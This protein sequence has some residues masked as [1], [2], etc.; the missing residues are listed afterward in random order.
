LKLRF[1]LTRPTRANRALIPAVCATALVAMLG[2]QLALTKGIELPEAGWSGGG[3]RSQLPN[4][5]GQFVP[6][7]LKQQSIFS[8]S[9]TAQAGT[10]TAVA[11]PLNGAI[12]AGMVSVR[13]R[14]YAVV[15]QPGGTIVRLPVGARY[16]GWRLRSLSTYGAVFEQGSTRLPLTFGA[17]PAQPSAETTENEEQ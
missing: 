11:L 7:I 17:L 4:V 14:S 16:A 8:P 10:G 13:G 9:R 1:P 6:P 12:V 15:Q 5:A 2:L 3:V